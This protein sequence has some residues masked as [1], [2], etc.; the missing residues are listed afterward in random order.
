MDKKYNIVLTIAGSDSS[1]GAGIQADIKTCCALGVYA[2]SV[3]TAVTAQNSHG[4]RSVEALSSDIVKEQLKAVLDDITPNAVKIGMI[5]NADIAEIIG[6]T[7]KEYELKNV[8]IDPVLKSTSGHDFS[9]N[10]TQEVVKS[11]LCPLSTLVTPNLPEGELLFGLS[12]SNVMSYFDEKEKYPFNILLK[13]GHGNNSGTVTDMLLMNKNHE[14]ICITHQK[15][16]TSNTHGTGCTLS[17]AIASFLAMGYG[18]E[19]SVNK[20]IEWLKCAL[21]KGAEYSFGS[22]YGP[23]NHIFK[24][25]E[26]WKL[27]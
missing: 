23:V 7:I 12:H 26:Q 24:Q 17:S 25:I 8:V 3:I 27:K 18:I 19:T 20:A 10:E 9:S 22:G 2:M 15:L 1:G 4:V 13:G 6:E 14:P 16:S 5:P 21:A 11:L